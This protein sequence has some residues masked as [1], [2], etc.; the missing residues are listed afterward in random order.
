MAV[1]RFA[2][3]IRDPF[4]RARIWL[5]TFDTAE[6]AAMVYDKAA[7]QIKGPNALTNFIKPPVRTPSPSSSPVV[8]I[9]GYDSG[10]ESHSL[11]SP[12]FVL[13]FQY[14][15]EAGNEPLVLET[16]WSSRSDQLIIKEKVKDWKP[17]LEELR[18][19]EDAGDLLGLKIL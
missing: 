15:V 14:T 19:S 13:R 9:T 1:G 6:E 17:P 11:S 16:N 8:D 10:K 2:A 18:E 12:T 5:G 7:I 3:E 4:R